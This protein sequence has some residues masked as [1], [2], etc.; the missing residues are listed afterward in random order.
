MLVMKDSEF[1]MPE[2]SSIQ[3]HRIPVLDDGL[4]T[5][6]PWVKDAL[7]FV[8]YSESAGRGLLICCAEGESRSPSLLIAY[9]M[10]KRGYTLK[11]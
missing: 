6:L 1:S 5:M 4:H 2:N 11:V 10:K 3:F 9:L 8:A 7:Q